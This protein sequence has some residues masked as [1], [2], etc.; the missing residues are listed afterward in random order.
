[1]QQSAYV[2]Q[3]LEPL[4]AEYQRLWPLLR[5]IHRRIGTLVDQDAVKACA[6]RLG[7]ID[8]RNNKKV[9]A[10]ANEMEADVFQDYLLY[11]HRPRGINFVRQMHNRKLYPQGSDEQRLLEAMAQARYSVF[12]IKETLPSAG[13]IALDVVRG[14]EFFI[15][16]QSV[17]EQQDIVDLLVGCRIFP[18]QT[19]WMHTGADIP[20]G[21]VEDSATLS[22]MGKI[23]NEKEER[24]LNELNIFKW[25]EMVRQRN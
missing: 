24:D 6:K 23:L 4:V 11:M 12:L 25:R 3:D 5:K 19:C 22:P 7:M 2:P 13:F 10:L 17:D 21:Q 14:E 20:I 15:L 8:K 16:N 9:I 18:Y 1:M